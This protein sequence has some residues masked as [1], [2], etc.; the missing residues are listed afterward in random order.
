[1][2]R[3]KAAHA[4]PVIAQA[5]RVLRQQS[6][7]LDRLEDACQVVI[8][9]GEEAGRELRPQRTGVEQ[10]RRGAHEVEAREQL[11]ELDRL[12]F[13]VDL[14]DG[15]SHRHAHEE[16]LR[17]FKANSA[18]VQEVAVVERLQSEKLKVAVALRHR[19]LRQGGRDRRSQL[20][21]EKLQL[22]SPCGCTPESRW[23]SRWST[24]SRMAAYGRWQHEA[25]RL[26]TQDV[27]QQTRADKR[28]VGFLFDE[29]ARR[30]RLRKSDL[31]L[32]DAVVQVALDL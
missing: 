4:A 14:A 21:V 16:C 24:V 13:A 12:R 31:V 8:N 19:A 5:A 26:V 1:M 28:V 15:K 7:V 3:T 22:R 11:V 25:E 30:H 2:S 20:L 29:R 32:E 18:F 27:E 23:R 6:I 10:R 17:Q 9:R